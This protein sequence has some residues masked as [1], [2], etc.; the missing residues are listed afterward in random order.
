MLKKRYENA[1]ANLFSD[2]SINIKNKALFK[3]F[4][5]YEEYKLKRV[6][7]I[8]KLDENAY[9]TLYA[10]IT[11]LRTVNRWFKNKAWK[12]LT[13]ANI[14][15]VYDNLEDGKILSRFGTPIKDKM[16]YYKMII[17]SKPFELAGKKDLV[18]EVMEFFTGNKK[19]EVRFIKEETFRKIIETASKPEH[20]LFL[21]LCWDIGENSTSILRLKKKD[22]V[23]HTNE[24]TKEQEYIINLPKE[25]LKRSRKPRSE[26]TNYKE[27]THYLNIILKNKENE[28]LIFNV[29]YPGMKKMFSRLIEKVKVKCIPK[30]QSVTLKD[31]RSSM[32]C[33]LLSKG[34]TCDEVNAR[35]GHRPSSREIDKYINYLAI[36]RKTPKKKVFDNIVSKLKEEVDNIKDRERLTLLRYNDLKSKF[37]E[38]VD[39][40]M[41]LGIKQINKRKQIKCQNLQK[42][43]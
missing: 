27:T 4:F 10:Y 21:W 14:K 37:N 34:W 1:K 24:D 23:K 43:I 8:A 30:G 29:G 16:T 20:R 12:D 32:A 41:E 25:I 42:T 39:R 33:D 2:K 35:L 38:L 5:E 18:L 36:D 28:D 17:R 3:K 26:I 9:R 15:E 13:K 6:N 40:V 31:L 19:E 7:S 22:C 11:R